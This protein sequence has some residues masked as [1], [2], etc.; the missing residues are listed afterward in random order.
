MRLR[1][2]VLSGYAVDEADSQG[3]SCHKGLARDLHGKTHPLTAGEW[4]KVPL[5]AFEGVDLSGL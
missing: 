1:R 5:D 4:A 2:W 3:K